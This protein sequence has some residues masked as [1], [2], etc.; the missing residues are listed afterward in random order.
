MERWQNARGQPV[1]HT[2]LKFY[3]LLKNTTEIEDVRKLSVQNSDHT[4]ST[5]LLANR[6]RS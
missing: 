3:I 6:T 1:Q 2:F 4:L 5:R